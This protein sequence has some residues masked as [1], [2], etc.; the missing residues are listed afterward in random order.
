MLMYNL[1]VNTVYILLLSIYV[2]TY[3][4]LIYNSINILLKVCYNTNMYN[5]L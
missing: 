5:F 3:N 2:Y 1:I 4:I